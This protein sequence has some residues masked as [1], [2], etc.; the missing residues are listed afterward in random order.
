MDLRSELTEAKGERAVVEREVHDQL[1]QLHALQLQLH[2]KKGQAE[3]SDTIKD[4]LVGGRRRCYQQ[5][6]NLL[7]NI[8]TSVTQLV[9][10]LYFIIIEQ[11]FT[12]NN[13]FFFLFCYGH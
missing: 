7:D 3:D 12:I 10:R 8:F 4:R 1:L 11:G 5:P 13:C 2:T 9:S 6:L